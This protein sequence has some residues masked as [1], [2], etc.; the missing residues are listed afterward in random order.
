MVLLAGTATREWDSTWS[1][2]GP[3]E[4]ALVVERI[5]GDAGG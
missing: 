4:D 2:V 3:I 5:V 1:Y